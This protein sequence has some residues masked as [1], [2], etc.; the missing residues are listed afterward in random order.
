MKACVNFATMPRLP[1]VTLKNA[2]VLAL[3]LGGTAWLGSETVASKVPD[4]DDL[5]KRHAPVIS[6]AMP[7]DLMLF[8]EP[9]PLETFG[10]REALDRELVVN[11]YRHSSTILYLKRAARWF[12]VIEPILEEE[13]IPTDF[14]YLAVIESGLSQVVSPAGAAGFW[15]FMKRTAP[16]YGLEVSGNVD[17]RYHVEKA[18]RAACAYLQEAHARF[19]SWVLAAASYNMGQAGVAEALFT[20][21]VSTYW[22]LHLNSETARYVYRLAA[23]R[24]VMEAPEAYGFH[25]G[26]SDVYA[27]LMCQEVVVD[28]AV[29]NLASFALASGTT[30]RELKAINPWLRGSQL[31]VAEGKSYA[32]RVPF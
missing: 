10:V 25:L 32:I 13:G 11:T 18:T 5:A 4:F 14:K 21:Q 31:D 7:G 19:G 27:P 24:E 8:G 28:T 16:E 3:V 12:P 26:R 22:D 23:L 17:E 15:Q 9:M 30:L 6:P 2:A 1:F 29:S 20:Q